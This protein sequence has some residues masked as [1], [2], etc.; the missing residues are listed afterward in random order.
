[1][2]YNDYNSNYYYGSAALCWALTADFRFLI[3]HT[4]GRTPWTGI[5][6]SQSIDL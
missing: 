4:V 5:I 6:Q 3:L 2:S 1:M